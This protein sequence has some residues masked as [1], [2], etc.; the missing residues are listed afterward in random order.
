M[1]E[2]ITKDM[3]QVLPTIWPRSAL[4]VPSLYLGTRQTSI[5]AAGP[6]SETHQSRV[7]TFKATVH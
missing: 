4:E 2:C 5:K 3:R 1:F 6:E 7:D